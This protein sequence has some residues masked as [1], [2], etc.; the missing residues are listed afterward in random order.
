MSLALDVKLLLDA[1]DGSSP[2][3]GQARARLDD[4]V[5]VPRSLPLRPVIMAYL[6]SPRTPH[7]RAIH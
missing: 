3:H 6:R 7:L 1:S 4:V 5:V 2:F